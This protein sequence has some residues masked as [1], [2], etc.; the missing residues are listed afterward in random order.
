MYWITQ[1]SFCVNSVPLLFSFIVTDHFFAVKSDGCSN[2][3]LAIFVRDAIRQPFLQIEV[4]F[5]LDAQIVWRFR[6]LLR[7]DMEAYEFPKLIP[8]TA[9]ISEPNTP[10]G[11]SPLGAGV[12]ILRNVERGWRSEQASTS[13]TPWT[14]LGSHVVAGDHLVVHQLL[15]GW[16]YGD[17]RPREASYILAN[18]DAMVG[19][20]GWMYLPLLIMAKG[21]HLDSLSVLPSCFWSSCSIGTDFSRDWCFGYSA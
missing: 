16:V 12:L 9:G 14:S 7:T 8:T 13:T 15:L 1:R 17:A 6:T 3:S 4:N 10:F 21:V 19:T 20:Q 2:L 5:E 11:M 18:S